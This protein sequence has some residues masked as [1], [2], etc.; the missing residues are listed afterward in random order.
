MRLILWAIRFETNFYSKT[1]KPYWLSLTCL[2]PLDAGERPF[3][4]TEI[5]NEMKNEMKNVLM[6]NC[7][8]FMETKN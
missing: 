8:E 6:L 1:G 5:K 7:D 4:K 3:L 2:V